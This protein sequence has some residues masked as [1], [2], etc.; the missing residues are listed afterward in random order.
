M[1]VVITLMVP[2][3][4]GKFSINFSPVG[5]LRTLLNGVADFTF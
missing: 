5:F 1:M 4:A 2:Y 3:S